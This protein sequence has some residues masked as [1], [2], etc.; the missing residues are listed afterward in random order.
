[1]NCPRCGSIHIQK[2]GT[3]AGKRKFKCTDCGANFTEGVPYKS[4]LCTPVKSTY[5]DSSYTQRD[6]R[7]FCEFRRPYVRPEEKPEKKEPS[8]SEINV[9]IKCHRCGTLNVMK[10][11]NRQGIPRYVCSDCGYIFL[12]ETNPTVILDKPKPP[13]ESIAKLI[14]AGG[15][16]QGIINR[17]GYTPREIERLMLAHYANE[18]ITQNQKTDIIKYGYYLKVPVDYMAEYIKCSEHKCEEVLR[19][20][21]KIMSTTH[22]AT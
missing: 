18:K 20:Y 3:R 15:N 6:E 5:E 16:V 12:D 17:Y 2:K 14:L 4:R 1:M 13:A 8:F 22:G 21:K 19:A 11:G 9:S 10:A 7:P